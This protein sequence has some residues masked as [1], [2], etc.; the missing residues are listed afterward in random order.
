[1]SK[2]FCVGF[3]S[4]ADLI[5]LSGNYQECVPQKSQPSVYGWEVIG[6]LQ[7]KTGETDW[8]VFCHLSL[9]FI[10]SDLQATDLNITHTDGKSSLFFWAFSH[11]SSLFPLQKN[12]TLT[13]RG[14][15]FNSLQ[16]PIL[17]FP[18]QIFKG[19]CATS[20]LR[21]IYQFKSKQVKAANF[22][23]ILEWKFS[24]AA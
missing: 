5:G 2:W 3:P 10:S 17:F 24:P 8:W 11:S 19:C 7:G 13:K 16:I 18:P 14:V 4:L 23:H 15:K 1:M 20:E 9:P 21:V 12:C 22:N 6:Q